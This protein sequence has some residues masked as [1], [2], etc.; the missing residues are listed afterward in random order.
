MPTEYLYQPWAGDAWKITWP[1]R[2]WSDTLQRFVLLPLADVADISCTARNE[3]TG[4]IINSR[5]NI[6]V[7]NA[8]NGAFV[9]G[10]FSFFFQAAD[11]ALIGTALTTDQET[12]DFRFTFTLD[13][14]TITT[15]EVSLTCLA[16]PAIAMNVQRDIGRLL[17][18]LRNFINESDPTAV[19][20]FMLY[21]YIQHG[22]QATN[23]RTKYCV[24]NFTEDLDLVPNQAG[25]E[26]P[27]NLLEIQFAW[28]GTKPL[29]AFSTEAFQQRGIPFLVAQPGTPNF[30]YQFGRTF[31]LDP[32][33][34]A[35]CVGE[36]PNPYVRGVITPP[37]F[38]LNGPVQLPTEFW[39][40]PLYWAAAEWFAGPLGRRPELSKTYQGLFDARVTPMA[41]FYG[42]RAVT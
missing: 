8:S 41:L 21:D 25:Y 2:Q 11:T 7:L 24:A 29:E 32:P 16:R 42:A 34:N 1:V 22:L 28:L 35:A 10:A 39:E 38:R 23:E 27:D 12:H 14:G 20:D 37:N 33:P 4:G 36:T 17:Q 5:N 31:Y 40:V 30:Y 9:D 13:D 19:P 3:S 15:M 6:S 18:T 26:M